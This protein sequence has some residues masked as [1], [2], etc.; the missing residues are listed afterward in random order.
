[1]STRCGA[2]SRPAPPE[3]RSRPR[4]RTPSALLPPSASASAPAGQR[5]A[6]RAVSDE[7]YR[8]VGFERP[9]LTTARQ[10]P[11]AEREARPHARKATP[12]GLREPLWRTVPVRGPLF[13]LRPYAPVLRRSSASIARSSQ[14]LTAMQARSSRSVSLQ[15]PSKAQRRPEPKPAGTL[16]ETC[17]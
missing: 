7:I 14:N 9:R 10:G 2:R 16:R 13:G 11:A 12:Q 3:P 1:M 8:S 5:R 15:T 17:I 4:R 6:T